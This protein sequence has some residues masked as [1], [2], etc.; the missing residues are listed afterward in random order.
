MWN[1]QK[2]VAEEFKIIYT[3]WHKAKLKYK[4][5]SMLPK[6][7][8]VQAVKSTEERPQTRELADVMLS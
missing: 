7:H 6:I 5:T 3:N 2:K 1:V 4:W 8:N